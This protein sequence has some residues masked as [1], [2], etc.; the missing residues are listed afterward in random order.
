MIVENYSADVYCDAAKHPYGQMGA[1]SRPATF[2][3]R[4]KRET[5]RQRRA[6]GW[7]KIDGA[8]ICPLCAKQLRKTHREKER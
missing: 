7:I 4:N 8:D 5:D 6:A 3:G 2:V 1:G